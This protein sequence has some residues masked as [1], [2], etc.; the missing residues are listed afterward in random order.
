MGYA[1]VMTRGP[2]VI[3]LIVFIAA[4]AWALGSDTAV[5]WVATVILF[6]TVVFLSP[7]IPGAGD[8]RDTEFGVGDSGV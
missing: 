3:A 4:A 5:A 8:S 6:E 1:D 7:W 2:F